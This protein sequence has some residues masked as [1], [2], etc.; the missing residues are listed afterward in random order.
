MV[1]WNRRL[2]LLCAL[3]YWGFKKTPLT[4]Y[5]YALAKL[6]L[7]D[8]KFI[9]KLTPGFKNHMRNLHNFR[10]AVEIRR[11]TFVILSAKTLIQ[12]TYLNSLITYVIFE[13]I[14]HF[15]RQNSSVFFYLKH[16]LLST[17]VAHQSANL[18]TFQWLRQCLPNTSRHFS[19]KKSWKIILLY[20]FRWNFMCYW[21]KYHIKVQ[22]FRLV[23]ASIKIHQIAH[24]IFETKSQFFFKCCITLH[25]HET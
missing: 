20:S 17:K 6:L 18:Q 16:Y 2:R 25:C 7:N 8:P 3:W 22:I 13:I 24:V 11:A 19:N 21:Q 14:S 10:Q 23:T 15:S 1:C 9:Q 4:I 12:M 5:T